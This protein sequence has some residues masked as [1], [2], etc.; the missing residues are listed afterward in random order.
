ML[1]SV[2]S[3]RVGHDLG[4]KMVKKVAAIFDYVEGKMFCE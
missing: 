4:T 3:Q 1:H 2:G